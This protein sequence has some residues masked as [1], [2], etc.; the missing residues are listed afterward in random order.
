LTAH[1]SKGLEF[2]QVLILDG[3]GWQQS[4]DEE[5]R[6]F[7]VAMTRARKTLTLCAKQ[8][9]RHAFIRDCEALCVKT[10]PQHRSNFPQLGRRTWLA[11]LKQVWLDWPGYFSADKPIHR[12]IAALDVGS[13][14]ILRTRSDGQAGWELADMHGETVTRMAQAFAP[15]K[16]EI[17]KVRVAAIS[18]RHKTA[19][20]SENLHCEYWEVVLPE[21]LYLPSLQIDKT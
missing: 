11:N 1:R 2:D 8:G 20:N 15:P 10:Q 18:V 21:I 3:G 6:L 7:Y 13:E 12:A 19:V 14:L 5:R 16:G 4:S 17:V 9:G